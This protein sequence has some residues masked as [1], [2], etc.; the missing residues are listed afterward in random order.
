MEEEVGKKRCVLL[1]TRAVVLRQ[2]RIDVRP[3]VKAVQ[4]QCADPERADAD[5]TRCVRTNAS[6]RCCCK[7]TQLYLTSAVSQFIC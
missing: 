2:G 4:L 1:K 7:F 3:E 6:L 5:G